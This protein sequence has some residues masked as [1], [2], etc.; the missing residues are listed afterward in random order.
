MKKSLRK[1]GLG[2][3]LVAIPAVADSFPGNDDNQGLDGDYITGCWDDTGSA[4]AE[5]TAH[6][7]YL[8]ATAAP[9][10]SFTWTSCNSTI[11]D[12]R[13]D[14]NLTAPGVLGQSLCSNFGGDFAITAST[15]DLECDSAF[16]RI[17]PT[18]SAGC[19]L[20]VSQVKRA[21]WCHEMGHQ[22]GLGHENNCMA[23]G[24]FVT[25]TYSAHHITHLAAYDY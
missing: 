19:G 22:L 7:N 17:N 3:W 23:T 25:N 11:T 5:L 9:H 12:A 13:F 15:A 21:N 2:A 4:P 8:L 6:I 18:A 14:D 20:N 24:C 10:L 1:L 16:V